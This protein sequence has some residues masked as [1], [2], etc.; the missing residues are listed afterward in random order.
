MSGH[1]KWAT[2]KRKKASIDAKRGAAFTKIIKE[3]VVAA[4]AGGGDPAGNARLRTVLE[5]AK[6]ANMPADNIKKAIMRGTGELEGVTYEELMYEGYGPAGVAL[7]IAVTTDNKNRSAASVRA[8]LSKANG[9]MAALGAVAWQFEQKGYITVPKEEIDEET[10]MGIALEAG[11]DDIQNED[12]TYDITTKPADF[13][14]VK[15]ALDDKKVKYS[16]AEVT[17]VPKNY[18]KVEGKAAEQM[19]R[20]MD[21]LDEDEDVQNVYANFDISQE[22]MD[23][24]GNLPE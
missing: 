1:S 15:K 21:A 19:L 10:L 23:R 2:I 18:V 13:E 11:A 12:A 4:R 9:A 20:L 5:K 14:A 17:M 8:I 22:E 6:G 7:L 16:S 24:I 3:I